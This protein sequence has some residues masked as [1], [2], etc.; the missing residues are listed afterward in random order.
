MAEMRKTT[1]RMPDHFHRLIEVEA[2]ASGLSFAGL[3]REALFARVVWGRR[4]RG[5]ESFSAASQLAVALRGGD[6]ASNEDPAEVLKTAQAITVHA[7]DALD[8][9]L[10][11]L[12]ACSPDRSIWVRQLYGIP[13]GGFA[14]D[15]I[16]AEPETHK[17]PPAE[18]EGVKSN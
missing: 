2:E 3:V 14:A 13:P 1:I 17:T 15:S 10:R 11:I 5:D 18:A 9:Q 12:D 16:L 7:A 8:E 6:N 4:M